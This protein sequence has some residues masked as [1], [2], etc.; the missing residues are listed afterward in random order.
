[1]P[2]ILKDRDFVSEV[3]IDVNADARTFA[4][5]YKPT[6]GLMIPVTGHVRGEIRSGVF[7]VRSLEPGRRSVLTAEIQADP[8][9]AIPAWIANFFE[10]SWPVRTFE[11]LRSQAAKPDVAMPEEFQ[12]VLAPTLQF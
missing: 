11:R 3:V 9:G 7:Q 5:V 10:R 2:F 6:D 12:N 4:L 8:K 1:M